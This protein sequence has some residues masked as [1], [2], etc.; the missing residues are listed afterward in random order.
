MLELLALRD[1]QVFLGSIAL[2][3]CIAWLTT[4]NLDPRAPVWPVRFYLF[5]LLLGPL[6][7]YARSRKVFTER[8]QFL[9]CFFVW[10]FLSSSPAPCSSHVAGEV[11]RH[12]R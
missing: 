8:E 12:Q 5:V 10:F 2:A 9:A 7:H 3:L 4:R 6:Q 1:V 11:A